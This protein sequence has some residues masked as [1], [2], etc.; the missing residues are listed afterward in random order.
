MSCLPIVIF[1]FTHVAID[2][3]NF[4]IKYR[5]TV[6]DKKLVKEKFGEFGKFYSPNVL[7]L[8]Y[9][10]QYYNMLPNFISPN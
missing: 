5:A 6:W 2:H 7:Q 4:L 8:N 3:V 1:H 10:Y 9:Y